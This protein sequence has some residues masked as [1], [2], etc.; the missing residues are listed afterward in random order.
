MIFYDVDVHIYN[1]IFLNLLSF[2]KKKNNNLVVE[3]LNVFK[4]LVSI[5]VRSRWLNKYNIFMGDIILSVLDKISGNI[6]I[7]YTVFLSIIIS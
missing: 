3:I 4:S 6:K 2:W 7:N 5:T 1:V